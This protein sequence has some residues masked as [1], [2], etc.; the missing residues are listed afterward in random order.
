V[1]AAGRTCGT[2]VRVWTAARQPAAAL[3]PLPVPLPLVEEVDDELEEDSFDD[4]DDEEDVLDDE[5]DAD[6]DA[7]AGSLEEE[8]ERLSVR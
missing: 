2:A 7:V 1:D 4:D 5:S 6:D 8:P 3:L